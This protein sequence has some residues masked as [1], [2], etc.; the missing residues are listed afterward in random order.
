MCR[1]SNIDYQFAGSLWEEL[2][3]D[4]IQLKSLSG[5]AFLPRFFVGRKVVKL[6]REFIVEDDTREREKKAKWKGLSLKHF[7]LL[8]VSSAVTGAERKNWV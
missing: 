8:L 7:F 6:A 4:G 2:L 5:G 3:S 1:L